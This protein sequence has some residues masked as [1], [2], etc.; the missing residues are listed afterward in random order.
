MCVYSYI[1]YIVNRL[2]LYMILYLYYKYLTFITFYIRMNIHIYIARKI[3]FIFLIFAYIIIYFNTFIF[4][5][6]M[7]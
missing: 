6:L 5:S 1:G 2:L 7:V 3:N 4:H